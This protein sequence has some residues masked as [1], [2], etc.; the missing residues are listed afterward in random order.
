MLLLMRRSGEAIVA[1]G[2]LLRVKAVSP[3]HVEFEELDID[4]RVSHRPP[5]RKRM[6][7]RVNRTARGGNPPRD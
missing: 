3:T 1:D 5:L 2:K 6:S 7:A 4:L